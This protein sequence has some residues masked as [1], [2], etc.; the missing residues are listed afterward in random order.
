MEIEHIINWS[1]ISL[2]SKAMRNES[3][4]C[5]RMT[6]ATAFLEFIYAEF[7]KLILQLDHSQIHGIALLKNESRTL[8]DRITN[9][10]EVFQ[11]KS[12]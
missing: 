1:L 9:Y 5:N 6:A 10:L 4:N 12:R 7:F 8:I 2:T 11:T 3:D